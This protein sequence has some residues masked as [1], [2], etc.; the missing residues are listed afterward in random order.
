VREVGD[1]HGEVADL[2]PQLTDFLVGELQEPVQEPELVHDLERRG[3]DRIAAEVA[4]EVRVLFQHEHADPG[5]AQQQAQH[6]A[7]RPSA[8]DTALHPLRIARHG[9]RPAIGP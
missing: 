6:H 3:V 7:G 5:A 8:G 2:R 1:R 9:G 4:Q